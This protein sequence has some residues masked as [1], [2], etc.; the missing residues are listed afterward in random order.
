M[1]EI[2]QSLAR[3]AGVDSGSVEKILGGVLAL[4]KDKVDPEAYAAVESKIPDAQRLASEASGPSASGGILGQFAEMAGKVLGS[5]SGG[6][7]SADLLGRFLKLGIPVS[8]LTAV[9][10]Q[11][12]KFL[13]THLP[14]DILSQVAK[15]LPAIPGV[16]VSALL[17]V[18]DVKPPTDTDADLEA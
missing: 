16:D 9:L 3:A 13:S 14:A 12:L 15:A 5:G 8:T 4:L 18:P 11:I 17:G 7:E 1:S 6:G 2:L 10:P